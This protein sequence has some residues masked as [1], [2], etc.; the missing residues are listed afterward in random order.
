M[1]V[2]R[3]RIL[4]RRQRGGSA[5]PAFLVLGLLFCVAVIGGLSVIGYVVSIASSAPPLGKPGDPGQSSVVFAADGT[6]LGFIESSVLRRPIPSDKIP[7]NMKN[8]TVAVEDRRFYSHQGVDFEGVIRAGIKNLRSGKTVEGG[9]TLTMQL[10]RALYNTRERTFKRKIREAKLAEELEDLHPGREGKAWI[11]SKYINSVPYGTEGGRTAIG[12][13]A[14]A[15]IYFDK[16]ASKLKVHEAAMLAGLPQAP[17]LYSPFS[18]PAK[19]LARRNDV[20][21]RMA[22]EHMIAP[23]TAARAKARTLGVTRGRF[24][25]SRRES[26]FFDYVKQELIERYGVDTVRKGGL[27]IKTT[28]DLRLQRRARAAIAGRLTAPGGPSSAVVTIDP[29]NGYIRAMASS[30]RYADRKFNLA[31]QGHRQPGSSFKTMALMTALRRGVDP[32]ATSYTSKA[33]KFRDPKWGP[34]EV[35]TYSNSYIGRASLTKATLASDNSIYMQLALDLGPENVKQTAEDMGIRSK[36]NGYPAETLGGLE[37]GVSP[38]EMANAYATIASGGWRNR[39]IAVTK[40]RFPDGDV[41]DLGRPRRH[42]AFP[43][44]V[45]LAATRILEMNVKSG[46]GTKA[47]IGCAV[48]GKTGTTDNHRDA[49]FVGYTPKLSTAVWVGYPDRRVEMTNLYQGGPVAGGTFPAEIWGDYMKGAKRGCP[50]F[51]A[52]PSQP[53]AFSAFFGKY[54]RQG[55]PGDPEGDE[56]YGSGDAVQDY[57]TGG[58]TGGTG[59]PGGEDGDGG[60][61]TG[62]GGGAGGGGGGG[63]GTGG[64]A[65]GGGGGGGGAG[66]GGGGDGTGGGGDGTGYDPDLYESAPAGPPDTEAPGSGGGIAAPE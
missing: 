46:T 51:P 35:K 19:A 58:G 49:W 52:Q 17:S 23:V 62:G 39:P 44:G 15:R 32:N 10:V 2:R 36:L 48:A 37:Y 25:T 34:I 9:S 28:V 6:R 8:A 26:F 42:K 65:G 13:Q 45:T 47:Q 18:A 12:I 31:A 43:D 7:Q 3:D 4:R 53:L 56:T 38:L 41:D 63:A 61:G 66:T 24:Y 29:N 50:T 33:L 30:A 5:K 11:L 27:S 60:A 21:D 40:V 16:P 64:G 57:E 1:S 54:A 14:A 55:A 59:G 20:L 22:S